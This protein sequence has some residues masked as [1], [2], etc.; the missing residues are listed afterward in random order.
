MKKAF[1]LI[2]MILSI[3]I[4]LLI[5]Q[6]LFSSNM[7][8]TSI[9]SDSML[10]SRQEIDQSISL[11]Y[12]YKKIS[13]ADSGFTNNFQG[14]LNRGYFSYRDIRGDTNTFYVYARDNFDRFS[15]NNFSQGRFYL[16]HFIGD[17]TQETYGEGHIV[18]NNVSIEDTDWLMSQSMDTVAIHFYL[19]DQDINYQLRVKN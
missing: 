3:A 9:Y 17:L 8:F 1:T 12:L 13:N 10:T 4:G 6:M 2:E 11:L 15:Q 14:R 7:L 16:M 5:F 19:G 18:L